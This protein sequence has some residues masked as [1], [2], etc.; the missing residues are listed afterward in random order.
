MSLKEI[1]QQLLDLLAQGDWVSGQRVAESTGC[2]R[3]YIWKAITSLRKDGFNI[4]AVQNCGYRLGSG[5][6]I[7]SESLVRSYLVPELKD[8]SIVLRDSVG[9]TND[10]GKL[11]A[12]SGCAEW[13][14]II[15]REQT[16]G[17]GRNDHTFFSPADTGLYMSIVLRPAIAAKDAVL[18]TA[19]AAVAVAKSLE[20]VCKIK[21]SIKWVNDVY[22]GGKKV[23]GILAES[24]LL[25]G[26]TCLEYV[27]LG[28]GINLLPPKDGFPAE[29]RDIAASAMTQ[30]N[31]ELRCKV[32]G[33]VLNT[34]K[35][36]CECLS[37]REYY[38]DYKKRCFFLKKPV[39]FERGGVVYRGIAER[40]NKDFELVV[41]LEDGKTMTLNSGEISVKSAETQNPENP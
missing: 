15:A 20:K 24:S 3:T 13:T 22:T 23:C 41:R 40:I 37:Y 38:N 11:F 35:D 36:Y 17:R 9:S 39:E 12:E 28:I 10:M 29:I 26:K 7:I 1:K 2:T 16:A 5:A 27:V 34:L 21:T 32:A 18:L 19:A 14:V 31:K 30:E 25:P 8:I 6:D 33:E 4:E